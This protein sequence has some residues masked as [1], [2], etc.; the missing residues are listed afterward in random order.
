MS[1]CKPICKLCDKIRI[2]TAVNVVGG[3]VVINLPAGAYNDGCKYCV[4]VAQNIPA[5][6]PVGANVLFT[7]G[8]GTVQYPLLN[9]CCRPV[10]V[11]SIRSRT[12]YSVTV[13]TTPTSGIFRLLGNTCCNPCNNL[14]SI[15]GTA[16]VTTTAAAAPV[17]ADG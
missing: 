16:P 8:T 4:I 1:N 10:T 5:T 13:E 17:R 6:A 14:L 11:C 15:N 2:S 7:I 12:K 9:R 3:N